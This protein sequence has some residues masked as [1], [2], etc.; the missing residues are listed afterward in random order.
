MSLEADFDT[1]Q[2]APL[3]SRELLDAVERLLDAGMVTQV[4]AEIDRRHG[5]G[6]GRYVRSAREW[7]GPRGAN[8]A[9][10]ADT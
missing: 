2:T 5:C 9:D 8:C 4:D 7:V 6:A 3:G 10:T 1:L